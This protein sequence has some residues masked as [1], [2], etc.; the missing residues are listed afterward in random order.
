MLHGLGQTGA[1]VYKW[2]AVLIHGEVAGTWLQADELNR[3]CNTS[4]GRKRTEK[5][6]SKIVL[7]ITCII[8][9][10]VLKNT[11]NK[12]GGLPVTFTAPCKAIFTGCK[13]VFLVTQRGNW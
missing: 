7:C 12:T 13:T 9:V 8:K 10:H 2:I 1:A 3:H 11:L 5:E 4:H 6:M